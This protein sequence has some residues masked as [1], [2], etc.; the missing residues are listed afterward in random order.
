MD[1]TPRT[2]LHLQDFNRPVLALVTVPNLLL[3]TVRYLPRHVLYSP[4]ED[5]HVESQAAV[6]DA[7]TNGRDGDGNGNGG[8]EKEDDQ[9]EI[10]FTQPGI[11]SIHPALKSAFKRLLEK[12]SVDLRFTYGHWSGLAREWK[13]ENGR[14]VSTTSPFQ[15]P[16]RPQLSQQP[17]QSPQS[18]QSQVLQ[19]QRPT[20]QQRYDLVITAE[21]IYSEESV[22]DLLAVLQSSTASISSTPH[23]SYQ[24]PP[25][26]QPQQPN[27]QAQALV[28]ERGGPE[29]GQGQVQARAPFMLRS[30]THTQLETQEPH[31]SES[32]SQSQSNHLPTGSDTLESS[33][34]DL[35]VDGE[36]WG[37]VPLRDARATTV[38]VAA[39][40]SLVTRS[41]EPL[42]SAQTC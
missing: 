34:G 39:K 37:V 30:T 33:L 25:Q 9:G 2:T 31:H 40:V 19:Q 28:P 27:I 29:Q 3:A 11:L 6:R 42:G 16:E 41:T 12:R 1:L 15:H 26:S 10:D 5:D 18:H 13:G 36:D 20:P 24:P 38:L 32:Q 23:P 22:H 4:I 21:T 14:R 7:P 8:E 35:R 17:E